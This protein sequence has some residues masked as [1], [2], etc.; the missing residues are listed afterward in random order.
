MEERVLGL[1][2]L[3]QSELVTSESDQYIH[4]MEIEKRMQ[5]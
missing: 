1:K 2:M 5:A 4:A 3:I